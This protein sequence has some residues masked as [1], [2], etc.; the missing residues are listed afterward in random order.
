MA[1][2]QELQHIRI[3]MYT[4]TSGQRGFITVI[5]AAPTYNMVMGFFE[6]TYGATTQS[7][8]QLATSG[9]VILLV[10]LDPAGGTTTTASVQVR[11]NT[12]TPITW[13]VFLI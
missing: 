10:R 8:T 1:A 2:Y 7:F 3:Y 6:W 9:G 4:F 12:T 13:S 11:V 5:A